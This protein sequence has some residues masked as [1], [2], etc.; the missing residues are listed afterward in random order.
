MAVISV[1]TQVFPGFKIIGDLSDEQVSN[2]VNYLKN[3]E[4]G[5][6]F[7]D[8]AIDLGEIVNKDGDDFLRAIVS[9]IDL[10]NK[11]DV[12]L[13]TLAKNLGESYKELSRSG[14][15]TKETNRLKSNLLQILSNLDK[16][17]FTNLI[18]SYKIE[19]S[20]N[21][22]EAKLLTDIRLI[23]DSQNLAEG[24]FGVIIHKLY[25]EYQSGHDMKELHLHIGVDDLSILKGQIENA[26]EREK[27]LRETFEGNIKLI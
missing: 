12:D 4:I 25:I 22:S 19:N 6:F 1:P 16:L 11:E 27:K 10:T 2:V 14:I 7:G 9:F 3:M 17:K 15:N 18:R 5:K 8:I 13:A 23:P 21:F 24:D 20:N 26:I